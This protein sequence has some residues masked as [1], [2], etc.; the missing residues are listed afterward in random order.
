M[1]QKSGKGKKTVTSKRFSIALSGQDGEENCPLTEITPVNNKKP[2]VRKQTKR[3][4]RLNISGQ[5]QSAK[6][7]PAYIQAIQKTI[8]LTNNKVSLY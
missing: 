1:Q 7:K 8:E 2:E 4:V 3:T 6:F 5:N